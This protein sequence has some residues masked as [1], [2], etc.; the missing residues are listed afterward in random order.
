LRHWDTSASLSLT[1]GTIYRR[2]AC[3]DLPTCC[4]FRRYFALVRPRLRFNAF[5]ETN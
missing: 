4:G 3:D 2:L 1:D 5:S